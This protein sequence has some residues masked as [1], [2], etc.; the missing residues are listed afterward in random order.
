LTAHVGGVQG[1]THLRE[2]LFNLAT[3]AFQ[4]IPHARECAAASPAVR[5][6]KPTEPPFYM[7]KCMTWD[8]NGPVVA[9][10][11]PQFI[12]WKKAARVEK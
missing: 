7:G 5:A 4:T 11:A 6:T 1:C 9:R 3:A 10:V 12:G 8:F 2:L